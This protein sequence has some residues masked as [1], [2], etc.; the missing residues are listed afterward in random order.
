M[1]KD[2]VILIFGVQLKKETNKYKRLDTD[3][4]KKSKILYKVKDIKK[5]F[6]FFLKNVEKDKIRVIDLIIRRDN[7]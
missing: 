7:E 4:H 2:S 1:V 6:C 5:S 3:F